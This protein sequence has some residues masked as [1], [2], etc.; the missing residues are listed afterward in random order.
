M[1]RANTTR[2]MMHQTTFCPVSAGMEYQ[3]LHGQHMEAAK[4]EEKVRALQREKGRG[5]GEEEEEG[6]AP[7]TDTSLPQLFLCIC[8]PLSLTLSLSSSLLHRPLPL[9]LL[10]LF[11]RR[12]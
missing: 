12:L 7:L 1:C 2:S 8:L 9:P 4:L 6:H 10:A 3:S 11:H 5:R